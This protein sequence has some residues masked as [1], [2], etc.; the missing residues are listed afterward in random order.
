MLDRQALAARRRYRLL[1]SASAGVLG[2]FVTVAPADAQMA[3][4]R[5]AVG[6]APVVT[7]STPSATTPLRGQRMQDA[8]AAQAANR[9]TVQSMRTIVTA[10]RSAA[11]AAVR[12]KPTDGLSTHGLDPAVTKPVLAA[13]DSTGLATWQ[14]A[15][16]PTQTVSG[17]NYTVTIKQTD[18]RALL[19]WNSFNVGAGTTLQF[20]QT[21]GG[22][23]QTGWI[24]LNRVVDPNASPTTIL[25]QIKADGTVLVLNRAGVIFG[26]GSQVNTH[27][28]L[29]S[30]LEIG[31]FAK[32]APDAADPGNSFKGLTIK[33]RNAAYLENGLLGPTATTNK[34]ATMITSALAGSIASR[35]PL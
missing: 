24:V 34:F 1:A 32:D 26:N 3:R 14:G 10:A 33:E 31:N 22:K 27:S 18:S 16:M 29:A 21:V 9:A 25:G 35:L 20:D 13:D 4:L 7:P 17:D 12:A 15:E 11:L 6:S 8:L 23:A 28:L 5:G 30:S 2:L 19:S